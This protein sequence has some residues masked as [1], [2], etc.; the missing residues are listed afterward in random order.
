MLGVRVPAREAEKARRALLAAG[1]L[2]KEYRIKR[3]GSYV[4]LPVKEEARDLLQGYEVVET[5]FESLEKRKSFE[6]RLR[7]LL[8]PQEFVLVRR[9][10]DIIGDLAILEVPDEL[11][12]RKHEIARALME[13]HKNIK[14]VFC[15]RSEVKGEA[16]VREL[17]HLAG[18]RRSE[19]V[20]RE[21][22]LRL[23]LDIAKVYFSPRLAYE[24]Q[25]VLKQVQDGEVIVD[26]FAGV[27]PFALLFARHR[28]VRVYAIDINPEAVR[29]L[30]ENIALNKLKGEVIPLLGDAREVAPRG[31]ASRV[32]MNLPKSSDAFLDLAFEVLKPEGGVV[33]FYTIAPE[34][35]LWGK[36]E[37]A[38]SVAK[39][40]G[41][42]LEVLEKRVV[43][44]YSPRNYH[45][46]FDLRV[47]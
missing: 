17:E 24:R 28:R 12:H 18:E 37:L 41:K 29:Y 46:V 23:K 43:R 35:N 2:A 42:R 34:E 36:A 7:E 20:H 27:G 1:A 38:R 3:Q 11:F 5:E 25:R 21:H 13:A 31:V 19:T 47:S 6:D 8:S 26:L 14:A 22:G 33:H 40:M 44:T 16:R 10:F 4:I 30:R 32:I 15:K 9:S 45:V 39:R